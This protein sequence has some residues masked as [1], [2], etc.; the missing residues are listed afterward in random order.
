MHGASCAAQKP[1]R[2]E[3]VFLN[4]ELSSNGIYA[5]DFYILG[6][7]ATVIIDDIIPLDSRGQ[8]IFGKVGDEDKAVW[9][10]LLEKAFAKVMGN[11]E[12]IESGDARNSIE[13]LTGAHSTR[14]YHVGHPSNADLPTGETQY[15][16]DEIFDFVIANTHKPGQTVYNM[17]SASTDGDN[18]TLRTED[19]LAQ[20]HVYTVFGAYEVGG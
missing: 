20:G 1:G 9:P 12:N 10:A 7:P 17:I 4:Q 8:L 15:N 13:F 19:T 14:Y 18:N 5:L 11:Y 6:V 3:N 16:A 2:I